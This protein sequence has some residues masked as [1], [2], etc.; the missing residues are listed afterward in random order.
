MSGMIQMRTTVQGYEEALRS[1]RGLASGKNRIGIVRGGLR[2]AVNVVRDQVAADM[3]VGTR[4]RTVPGFGFLQPGALKRTVRA[5]TRIV[6]GAGDLSLAIGVDSVSGRVT[7]GKR[8]IGV[9]WAHF[10]EKG[11]RPHSLVPKGQSSFTGFYGGRAVRF[12]RGEREPH[13][14]G[15]SP[16]WIV[17]AGGKKAAARAGEAFRR[18]VADRMRK[19]GETGEAPA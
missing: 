4:G 10:V 6:K 8:N 7:V 12:V 13:H 2:A 18:Y 9:Y 11:T 16:Q 17:F 1:V 3:P 15:S 14:P 5:S 19:L